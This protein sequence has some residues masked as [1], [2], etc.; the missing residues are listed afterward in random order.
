MISPGLGL[1]PPAK[2]NG[3]TIL[4]QVEKRK[5]RYFICIEEQSNYQRHVV[6]VTILKDEL[7]SIAYQ[8]S[9]TFSPQIDG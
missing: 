7:P 2:N 1:T 5:A 3:K 9:C 8:T 6:I 4:L